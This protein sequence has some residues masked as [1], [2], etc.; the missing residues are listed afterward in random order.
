MDILA[1]Q[2][3]ISDMV[4]GTEEVQKVTADMPVADVKEKIKTAPNE[5][6]SNPHLLLK[7]FPLFY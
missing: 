5:C 4:C 2:A 1:I 7:I 6:S 3:F